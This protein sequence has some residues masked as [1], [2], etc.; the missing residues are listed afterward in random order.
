[1]DVDYCADIELD[2]QLQHGHKFVTPCATGRADLPTVYHPAADSAVLVIH[3]LK[4]IGTV[5]G[6]HLKGPLLPRSTA[7]VRDKSS[8]DSKERGSVHPPRNYR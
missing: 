4:K 7:H 2:Q 3:S 5:D 6:S 8:R 1:M